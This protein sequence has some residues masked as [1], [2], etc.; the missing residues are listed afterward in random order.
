MATEGL[1]MDL[2]LH[3]IAS[4]TKDARQYNVP[5]ANELLH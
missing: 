1:P 5:T 4:R 2:Q 3:L